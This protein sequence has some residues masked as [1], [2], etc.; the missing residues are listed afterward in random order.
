MLSCS[1][2]YCLSGLF[3][4]MGGVVT[5]RSNNVRQNMEVGWTWEVNR[6]GGWEREN[7]KGR[8]ETSIYIH[9]RHVTQFLTKSC[10]F[11]YKWNCM[12]MCT[13]IIP[14]VNLPPE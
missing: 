13:S 8:N 2:I 4:D 1:L 11:A 3:T 6:S 10:M 5:V 12:T 14:I 9:G 7:K